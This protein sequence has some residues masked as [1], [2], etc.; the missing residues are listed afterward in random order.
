MVARVTALAPEPAPLAADK[1]GVVRVGGTRVTLDSVITAFNHG[2]TAE[3][4]VYKYPTLRLEDVYTV[5]AYYLWHRAEID[6]YLAE[7]HRLAEKLQREIEAAFPK[8]RI[9]ERLLARRRAGA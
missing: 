8:D 7:E 9:R 5:I 6:A 1:D 2:C 3:E 4:I